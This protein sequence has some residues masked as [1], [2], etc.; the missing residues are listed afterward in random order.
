[1]EPARLKPAADSFP[2]IE[3]PDSQGSKSATLRVT[4]INPCTIAENLV[5]VRGQPL[6]AQVSFQVSAGD[7]IAVVGLNGSGKPSLLELDPY[8]PSRF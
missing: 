8:S 4:S 3:K 5:L 2:G 7:R 1:M 6:F